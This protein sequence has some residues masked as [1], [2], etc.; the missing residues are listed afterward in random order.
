MQIFAQGRL[1]FPRLPGLNNNLNDSSNSTDGYGNSLVNSGANT[2]LGLGNLGN[3]FANLAGG[4]VNSMT[5]LIPDFNSTL[6]GIPD[7]RNTS[8]VSVPLIPNLPDL[9]SLPYIPGL[10][11]AV[12]DARNHL[13]AAFNITSDI[14]TGIQ[15]VIQRGLLSDDPVGAC[16]S[17]IETILRVYGTV[18]ANCPLIIVGERVARE[19]VRIATEVLRSI[20]NVAVGS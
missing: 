17:I 14:S 6:A 11:E 12:A 18:A 10:T 8:A 13:Q 15:E 20:R 1:T 9:A 7:L 3:F 19:G 2:F 4:F 16:R 5:S